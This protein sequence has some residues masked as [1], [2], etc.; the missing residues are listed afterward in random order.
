M[1]ILIVSLWSN[2]EKALLLA[3]VYELVAQKIILLRVPGR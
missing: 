3:T 2:H 1:S